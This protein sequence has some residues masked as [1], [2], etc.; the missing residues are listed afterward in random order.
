MV[1][2]RLSNFQKRSQWKLPPSVIMKIMMMIIIITSLLDSPLAV[3]SVSL[4]LLL[5]DAS[6]SSSSPSSS[7]YNHII[8][9]KSFQQ[10]S[11][12]A[13]QHFPLIH[14]LTVQRWPTQN[15]DFLIHFKYKIIFTFSWR[16]TQA[17]QLI[18]KEISTSNQM[19]QWTIGINIL[20]GEK[21]E[22]CEWVKRLTV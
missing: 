20:Q 22:S 1:Q 2:S 6:S 19:W 15:C 17:N 11:H 10:F 16:F 5:E 21:R 3:D 7:V 4:P 14:S 18:L 13:A 12:E 9:A 8:N